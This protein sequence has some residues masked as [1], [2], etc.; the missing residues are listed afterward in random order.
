MTRSTHS[1]HVSAHMFVSVSVV[2]AV[3]SIVPTAADA[4]QQPITYQDVSATNLPLGTLGNNSMDAKPA[5]IDGD[6]DLDLVIASEFRPNVILINDGNGVFTNESAARIAQPF[7]DS[8][9]VGIAD[10][11]GDGDLDIIFVSEDDQTNE[12]YLND[13]TGVFTDAGD[14][15][16]VT[17][18]SNAVLV[19]FINADSFPDIVIGNAGQNVVLIND[20]NAQ[21]TNETAARLPV[22]LN[23][24]QDL[25]WGDVDGDG[26]GD[27]VEG[28]ENGN[29]LLLNDGTGVFTDATVG[30][31]PLPGSGE[32]TREADL[33]DIDGDGDLDLFL[34]NVTFGQG[35]PSLNRLLVNDGT[36]VFSD[37]SA[38]NLPAIQQNTVDGDFVDIDCDGDLDIVTA[39][40]FD[41]TYQIFENDGTGVFTDATPDFFQTLPTG[42]GIDVEAADFTGDG[43]IDLYL[44]GFQRTD[45][46]FQGVVD[47]AS[48]PPTTPES[49]QGGL[50]EP[51]FRL[52]RT[53]PNPV[54][55]EAALQLL[56]ATSQRIRLDVVDT[57]GRI[58]ARVADRRYL[59]GEHLL[60][61]DASDLVPGRYFWRATGA[62]RNSSRSFAVVR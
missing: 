13:G 33:G 3:G 47:P 23:V 28:N 38:A 19:T 52:Y 55:Q 44:T 11:D 4:A 32:E 51:S 8:E 10:F 61:L 39:Q 46:L 29:R 45:Y 49:D 58:V 12:F 15:I 24:T 7:H 35:A 48:T 42:N 50:S 59:P 2:L 5:D 20:G 34:A 9:D 62:G 25:E 6:Q 26:D 1:H 16:P 60:R 40:A 21:F 37:V 43:L 41:G 53:A 14:R 22:N 17:G 56:V 30:R 27:I 18:T 31:L 36:G 57:A 54:S